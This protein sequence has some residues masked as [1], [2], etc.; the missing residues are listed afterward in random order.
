[1]CCVRR[2]SN[3]TAVSTQEDQQ[4][5]L[6]VLRQSTALFL[7]IL[8]KKAGALSTRDTVQLTYYKHRLCLIAKGTT[9]PTSL[10]TARRRH[11][12]VRGLTGGDRVEKLSVRSRFSDTEKAAGGRLAVQ[13]PSFCVETRVSF[14]V[15]LLLFSLCEW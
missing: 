9:T 4:T 5:C 15:P 10:V 11:P 12:P 14:V 13:L 3:H 6:R 1:M 7:F 2:E 8:R